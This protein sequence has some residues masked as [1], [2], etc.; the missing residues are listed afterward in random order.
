[1]SRLPKR[2]SPSASASR[3]SASTGS[4]LV[5][6]ARKSPRNV[7]RTRT[8]SRSAQDDEG[9]QTACRGHLLSALGPVLRVS[10]ASLFGTARACPL[11]PTH[12]IFCSSP[13]SGLGNRN[14]QLA[15]M[16][17][18]CAPRDH[19]HLEA[20]SSKTQH[21]KAVLLQLSLHIDV[22]LRPLRNRQILCRPQQMA[23]VLVTAA[24]GSARVARVSC[25]ASSLAQLCSELYAA[26]Q[27]T[28]L[29][30]LNDGQSSRLWTT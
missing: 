28:W 22:S 6:R 8:T 3:S 25:S 17:S 29:Q 20:A 9:P 30:Q 26:T 16:N 18:Q 21:Q 11:S 14:L 4:Q 2:S 1:M 19:N 15:T 23:S 24:S 27:S 7:K 13:C 12:R 10:A 5:G